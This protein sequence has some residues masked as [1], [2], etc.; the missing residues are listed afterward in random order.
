M[1]PSPPSP[2]PFDHHHKLHGGNWTVRGPN[3]TKSSPPTGRR[4]RDARWKRQL[5][6]TSTEPRH[7]ATNMKTG[8]LLFL[9]GLALVSQ[10][11][12]AVEKCGSGNP[13]PEAFE[14]AARLRDAQRAEGDGL[15]Y[16][17][18]GEGLLITT[19]VHVVED[20]Q[21]AGFVTD[22]MISDQ[23]GATQAHTHAWPHTGKE[24]GKE[25]AR[26]G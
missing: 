20:T 9:A 25:K 7:T 24:K 8:T 26:R 16:R 10:A 6:T 4:A 3:K 21:H 18:D 2:S 13:E 15:L 1:N 12:G 14:A 19:Y 5:P 17:R 22:E 11:A 23:V